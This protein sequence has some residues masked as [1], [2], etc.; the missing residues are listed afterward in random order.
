MALN[1]PSSPNVNATYTFSNKTWTYNGNAWA[2]SYGTLNTGVV[3]EGSNLYFS[4]ARAIA[5][6]T[7]TSLSNI[8]VTNNVTSGASLTTGNSTAANYQSTGNVN[9]GNLRVTTNSSLGTVVSGTWNG[10][11]I[12]TTYTDAKIVA[13][14]NT[15]PVSVTTSSGTAT[16]SLLSSGVSATTY[17]GSTAIPVLTVDTYGRVTSASNVSVTSGTTITDDTTTNATR[18]ITLTSS[19][20]GSIS[21]ANVSTSKLFFNPS[22]GLLTSTDYNSSSDKRLKRNIKTVENAVETITALRGVTFDW[23]EGSTKGIGLIAQEVEK[24]I[25]E[26]VNTDE[27]GY[28]GIKYTNIIGILVEAIK[29]QQEQIN[30]LKKQIEKL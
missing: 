5:A 21:T 1:F 19:S 24:I 3:S 17:G 23:K 25:P 18:Y 13:V 2:L 28:K 20:S 7:N 30:N 29:E 22:T 27:D 15:A 6:I 12:S 10:T 16:V 4:N 26:V 11:S 9:S 14:S 8:T